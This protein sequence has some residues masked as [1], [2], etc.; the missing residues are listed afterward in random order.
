VLILASLYATW[1]TAWGV[2]GHPPRPALDD[3]KSISPVVDVPLVATYLLLRGVPFALLLSIP[4]TLTVTEVARNP[5]ARE[6]QPL[7]E[8]AQRV[9]RPISWGVFFWVSVFAIVALD[10]LRVVFWFMD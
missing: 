3:P 5:S 10:P 8:P 2:L 9:A 4:L 7:K 6:N 1:I